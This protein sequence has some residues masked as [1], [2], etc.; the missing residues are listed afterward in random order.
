MLV[1]MRGRRGRIEIEFLRR[2][3][4]IALQ[5]AAEEG[6]RYEQANV[7]QLPPEI[8]SGH[9]AETVAGARIEARP[10]QGGDDHE[11]HQRRP[12]ALSQR[13]PRPLPVDAK[14]PPRQPDDEQPPLGGELQQL[15][16]QLADIGDDLQDGLNEF[17]ERPRKFTRSQTPVWER[18]AAKLLFRCRKKLQFRSTKQSFVERGSQTEFGNQDKTPD[19]L[20]RT[21]G[22][23]ER[24]VNRAPT[25]ESGMNHPE[26]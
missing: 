22:R 1:A 17:H 10:G 19:F 23:S 12:R 8:G 2:P 7:A 20:I 3:A 24:F 9:E 16:R 21:I 14:R 26:T 13:R 6:D 4:E 18:T 5:P 15:I 25:M 11:Q